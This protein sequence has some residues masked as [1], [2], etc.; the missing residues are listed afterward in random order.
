MGSDDLHHKRK[1][2]R[3]KDLARRKSSRASYDRVLIVCE[4]AKTEPNYLRELIDCLELNSA[5]VEVDG[6]SGSSPISVVKHAKRRY[7]E[8]QAKG[9]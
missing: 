7:R 2:R 8:E 5:N 9:E 3:A 4:G 6:D 1:A